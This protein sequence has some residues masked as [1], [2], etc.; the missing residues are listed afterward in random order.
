ML[1]R[2]QNEERQKF[3][4]QMDNELSAQRKQMNNMM[5]ANMKSAKQDRELLVQQNQDLQNR[6][7][8]FQKANEDNMKEIGKLRDL[9][10]KQDEEKRRLSEQ[11]ELKSQAA[12]ERQ[13]QIRA[14]MVERHRREKAELRR[15]MKA[16]MEKTFQEHKTR[17]ATREQDMERMH[18]KLSEQIKTQAYKE[19]ED[20]ARSLE[21]KHRQQQDALRREIEEKRKRDLDNFQSQYQAAAETRFQEMA[22]MEGK[23]HAVEEELADIKKPGFFKRTWSKAKAFGSAVAEKCSIMWQLPWSLF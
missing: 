8:A 17:S 12:S 16:N 2:K 21:A 23:M 11:M 5:E 10:A 9:L 13:E 1:G 22:D 20:L 4:E 14:E 18:A 19:R 3:R 6:F 15:Q 7:L